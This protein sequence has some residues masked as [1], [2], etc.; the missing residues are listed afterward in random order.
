MKKIGILNG[1]NLNL[2]GKREPEVYGSLTLDDLKKLLE[3]EALK[4]ETELDFFQSNNEGSLI[5]KI[6]YWAEQNFEGIV[7]NPGAYTHTSI[8]IRDAIA[9]TGMKVI[10]VHISNICNR[11]NFRQKSLTAPVSIGVITGLGFYSYISA[12][13]YFVEN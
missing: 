12:L 8:A 11:E 3:T 4:L 13:R 2:L 10:E 7:C 6:H 1:P 5:D 9:G